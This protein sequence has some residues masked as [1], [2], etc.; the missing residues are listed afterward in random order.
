L[1]TPQQ[2]LT[3]DHSGPGISP[4]TVQVHC[5]RI[6][7]KMA[8]QSFVDLVRFADALDLRRSVAQRIGTVVHAITDGPTSR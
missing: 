1:S 3:R 4:M 7:Q 2:A 8:V 6:M 5:G